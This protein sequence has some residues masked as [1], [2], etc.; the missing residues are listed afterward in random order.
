MSGD[1]S[2]VIYETY[3]DDTDDHY[4]EVPVEIHISWDTQPYNYGG[5]WDGNRG[6]IRHEIKDVVIDEIIIPTEGDLTET[7]CDEIR[8]YYENLGGEYWKESIV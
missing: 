8:A 5:D 1:Q 4:I 7:L 2:K 6:E 3:Q